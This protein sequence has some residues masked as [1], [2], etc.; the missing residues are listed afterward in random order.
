MDL[1][2]HELVVSMSAMGNKAA[3]LEESS[4]WNIYISNTQYRVVVTMHFLLDIESEM[5]RLSLLFQDADLAPSDIPFGIGKCLNQLDEMKSTNGSKLSEFYL[6][7]V[8]DTA[9]F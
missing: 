9:S 7:F 5:A 2:K 6:G 3:M 1:T 4:I 8:S